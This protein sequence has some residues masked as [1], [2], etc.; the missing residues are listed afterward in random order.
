MRRPRTSAFL[1]FVASAGLLSALICQCYVPTAMAAALSDH[2]AGEHQED[3]RAEACCVM[4]VAAG[5]KAPDSIVPPPA[6]PEVVMAET[7]AV[8]KVV[9][10][11][12]S[13][14][15]ATHKPPGNRSL[16]GQTC[17]LLI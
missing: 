8:V 6:T 1:T 17:V 14:R 2:C 9:A 12:I 4:Q 15:H 13:S 5:V 10:P 3:A 16:L 7:A 11:L